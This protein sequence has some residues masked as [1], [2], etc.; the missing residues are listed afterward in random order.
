M[1]SVLPFR[2]REGRYPENMEVFS[3]ANVS[4]MAVDVSFCFQYD[5]NATTFLLEPA[6]TSLEPGESKVSTVLPLPGTRSFVAESIRGFYSCCKYVCTTE[7]NCAKIGYE[8]VII[9]S[10]CGLL[11]HPAINGGALHNIFVFIALH[12]LYGTGGAS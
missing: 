3:I 7:P 10:K 8:W 4:M 1:S 2:Y 9:T 5:H 11:L 6:S 12:P